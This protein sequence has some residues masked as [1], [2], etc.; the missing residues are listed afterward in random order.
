MNLV[1]GFYKFVS[2]S[3]LP[4]LQATLQQRASSLNLLGTILISAEGING[5][6]SGAKEDIEVWQ[7]KIHTIPALSDMRIHT[8]KTEN[9]M[10]FHKLK[11]KIRREIIPLADGT[12]KPSEHRLNYLD[13]QAWNELLLDDRALIIDVR[14][15]FEYRVGKFQGAVDS[16]LRS[17]AQLTERLSEQPKWSSYK[18]VGMYC[19]GGIRCEKAASFWQDKTDAEVYQLDGGII[20]YLQTVAPKK[21][22]WQGECFV[23]DGRVSLDKNLNLGQHELCFGCGE[24]LSESERCDERYQYGISCPHCHGLR[25]QQALAASKERVRQIELAKKSHRAYHPTRTLIGRCL[26]NSYSS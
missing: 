10:P 9:V 18:S 8:T 16:R 17:F 26:E 1:A 23:F 22:L 7:K 20:R 19:T 12:I 25:S 21:N 24:P 3:Q 11:I 13:T 6:V 5:S 15:S 2:L 14:N 4:A